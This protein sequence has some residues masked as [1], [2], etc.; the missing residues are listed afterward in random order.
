V[1]RCGAGL[2]VA[3]NISSRSPA[4][5]KWPSWS[6]EACPAGQYS[7]GSHAVADEEAGSCA[8]CAPNTFQAVHSQSSCTDC[9][10]GKFAHG[11]GSTSCAC[12]AGTVASVNG[13]CRQR[14]TTAPPTPLPA[15]STTKS[16][17]AAGGAG[18]KPKRND[19]RTTAAPTPAP[20]SGGGGGGGGG[21]RSGDSINLAKFFFGNAF[22]GYHAGPDGFYAVFHGCFTQL[23]ELEKSAFYA[24]QRSKTRAA[25]RR[26]KSAAK[27]ASAD[28]DAAY[29]CYARFGAEDASNDAV[30]E[31][32]SSWQN[33]SSKRTFAFA[34]PHNPADA[35]GRQVRRL[36]EK[37]NKAARGKARRAYNDQVRSLIDYIKRRDKRLPAAEKWFAERRRAQQAEVKAKRKATAAAEHRRRQKEMGDMLRQIRL[38]E[39]EA[40]ELEGSD[41]GSDGGGSGGV[42]VIYVPLHATRIMLTI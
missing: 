15:R 32:Y 8:V 24:A 13:A 38:D 42:S 31:F 28:G 3:S 16:P 22:R 18:T 14:T 5:R 26:S 30:M 41:D 9:P 23:D 1:S 34:D 27:S 6:C 33:F 40:M 4:A 12:P 17:F 39:L 25:A 20:T 7:S 2:H 11:K 37:E 35:D 29:D 21:A 10:G 36:M 19:T